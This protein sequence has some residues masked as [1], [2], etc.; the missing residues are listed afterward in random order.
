MKVKFLSDF[1]WFRYVA[2]VKH[3]GRALNLFMFKCL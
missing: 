1:S 3:R 2:K